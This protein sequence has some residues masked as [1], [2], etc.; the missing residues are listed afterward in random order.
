[1]GLDDI[2]ISAAGLWHLD[3]QTIVKDKT[4]AGSPER[5]EFRFVV[6]DRN[7][8]RYVIE[9]LLPEEIGRK[10]NIIDTLNFLSTKGLTQIQSY[11]PDAKQ[12]YILS[13]ED[14]FWQLSPFIEG[15]NLNRPDYAFD[16]WRGK[17]LADFLIQLNAE[18]ADVP[19][20]S[21]SDRFSIKKYIETLVGQ[22]E[23]HEPA[24]FLKIQPVLAF[25]E[26][27]FMKAHDTIPNAF[28][29]GDY[30]PL[31]II[32]SPED[33]RRVIDWEFSGYKPEIYDV[34]N[35]IGCIGVE[36]PESLLHDLVGDFIFYLKEAKRFSDI[37]WDLLLEF[38]IAL[39]FAWLSEWLRHN[40]RE[41][42]DLETTYLK[43]LL[44][45]YANLRDAWRV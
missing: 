8:T 20:H 45:N 5:C 28:C 6:Q 31:N 10:Q 3:I 25:L 7:K 34:A 27:R 36:L 29:H 1:M 23:R 30:H 33:I 44:N 4:I 42:I 38:V 35:M 15:T 18:S 12:A 22:I 32:W 11:L 19:G 16:Q 39:R 14:R 9:S 26:S 17:V 2:V 21:R 24:L 37:S 13:H 43:L 41:M 40:D